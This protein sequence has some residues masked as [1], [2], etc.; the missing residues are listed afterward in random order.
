MPIN[1]NIHPMS[2]IRCAVA[3]FIVSAALNYVWEIAQIRSFPERVTGEICGGT[4]LLPA[5]V[6]ASSF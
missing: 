1:Y 5:W 2:A 6:T 3:I 4:A